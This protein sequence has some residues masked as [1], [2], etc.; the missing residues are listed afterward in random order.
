MNLPNKISL[1][2]IFLIIVVMFFYLADSLFN[3]YGK[4]VALAIYVIAASTDFVDGMIARKT[5]Q[6]TNLGKFLDET[7]DKLLTTAI[8]L[9]LLADNVMLHPLGV[10]TVFS[11]LA[12][13]QI[14]GFMRRMAV[15]KG[16][17]IGADKLGKIKTVLLDVSLALIML[18]SVNFEFTIMTGL[19]WTIYLVITYT[20]FSL[21][22]IMNIVSAVNYMI[23]Y[24]YV[25]KDDEEENKHE[26]NQNEEE[27][28]LEINQ[29]EEENKLEN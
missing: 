28:R 6:V 15:K 16:V 14:I 26:I 10:I 20:I 18:I 23:K 21:G 22:L 29:N 12:R 17:V 27:N 5:N 19:V 11:I 4:V 9:M 1:S 3:G 24:F 7:A 13:D 8:L 25:F 2:R